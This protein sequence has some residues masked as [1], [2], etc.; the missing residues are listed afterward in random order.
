MSNLHNFLMEN[1][2]Y[3][4][5]RDDGKLNNFLRTTSNHELK[6]MI[7][8]INSQVRGIPASANDFYGGRLYVNDLIAP[9]IDIKRRIL[10][11]GL[12][13]LRKIDNRKEKGVLMYYLIN[14]LHLF[15]DGNGRTSRVIYSLLSDR[16]IDLTDSSI[17]YT[18]KK[19]MHILVRTAL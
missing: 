13:A 5:V 10:D 2:W 11:K 18:M 4:V 12:D 7:I 16:N 15:S 17:F 8:F 19:I 6:K 3:E 14:C 9:T 1:G